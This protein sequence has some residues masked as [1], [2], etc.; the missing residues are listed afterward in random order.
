M[1]NTQA[2]NQVDQLAKKAALGF[3]IPQHLF[4]NLASPSIKPHYSL[5]EEQ[6]LTS[7]QAIK[8]QG[9]WFLQNC[10]ILPKQDSISILQ[11]LHHPFHP[12]LQS[13]TAYLRSQVHMIPQDLHNLQIL[14]HLQK[15]H[16]NFNLK[17][18]SFLTHQA[19]G[20]LPAADW[21]LD[22]THMHP[23]KTV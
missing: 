3:P 13:L 6:N 18:P 17:S 15:I 7:H 19:R 20:S 2:N 22:L 9:R 16:P 11:Y 21:Q 23:G 5:E 10:L 14:L 1:E 12:S 4:L 8:K